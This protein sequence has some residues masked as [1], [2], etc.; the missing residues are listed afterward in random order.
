MAFTLVWVKDDGNLEKGYNTGNENGKIWYLICR[1][2]LRYFLMDWIWKGVQGDSKVFILNNW[3]TCN[4][5][6]SY[7][8][9]WRKSSL[10]TLN[11]ACN[12]YNTT[13]LNKKLYLKEQLPR[14]PCF[15]WF[16]W[17][18][19]AARFKHKLLGQERQMVAVSQ[20][21]TRREEFPFFF[22][23]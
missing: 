6:Y 4:V 23:M 8:E 5:V 15:D 22:W 10:E 7:C 14:K 3:V 21:R 18:K 12:I 1:L 19:S 20:T 11:K 17:G 9:Y 2:N 13:M 16:S